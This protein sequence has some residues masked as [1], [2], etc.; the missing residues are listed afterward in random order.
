MGLDL[1][2]GLIQ[3]VHTSTQLAGQPD[4]VG[5]ISTPAHVFHRLQ[6]TP[7]QPRSTR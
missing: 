4:E 7:P 5:H 3:P 1:E 6:Y 2:L